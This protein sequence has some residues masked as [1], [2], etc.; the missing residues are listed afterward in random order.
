MLLRKFSHFIKTRAFVF[1]SAFIC[2]Y[3]FLPILLVPPVSSIR[4]PPQQ[5]LLGVCFHSAPPFH[6]SCL[7]SPVI[8]KLLCR[9][10][11]KLCERNTTDLNKWAD[12]SYPITAKVFMDLDEWALKVKWKNTGPRIAKIFLKIEPS[13][14][15]H[16]IKLV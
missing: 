11:L 10:I 1:V 9:Y 8:P 4:S 2:S 16:I 15:S 7:S 3:A 6:T 13:A 14:H 5:V 12:T